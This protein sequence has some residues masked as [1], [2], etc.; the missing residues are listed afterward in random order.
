M[1]FRTFATVALSIDTNSILLDF[2]FL[3][4]WIANIFSHSLI[5]FLGEPFAN[6]QII[7]STPC[8]A[9][10][11][12]RRAELETE[13]LRERT[14]EAV[15]ALSLDDKCTW[16]QRYIDEAGVEN[17]KSYHEETTEFRDKLERLQFLA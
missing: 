15:S 7:S 3:F 2:E 17:A 11:E 4:P 6:K 9:S 14:N 13:Y 16:I 1:S 12:M 5:M 10:M 8:S